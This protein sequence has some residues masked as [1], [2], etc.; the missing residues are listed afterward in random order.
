MKSI[1]TRPLTDAEQAALHAGLRSPSAFTLRRCQ[2]LLASA[3]GLTPPAIARTYGGS[4]QGVRNVL[5]AFAARGPDCLRPRSSAPKA[6]RADWPRDRDADL[7][8]LVRQSPRALG[9]ATS[10]WTLDLLAAACHES[11]WTAR[12]LSGEA[13]RR[14]LKRLG[15]G[16]TRAKHWLT[17]P[18]PEYAA[19][20]KSGTS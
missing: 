14:V 15:V 9:K 12:A 11:G 19:K 16:W 20:K 8:A 10:L 6:P 3:G 7:A 2:Y 4:D 17:S 18:D 1:T 13:I 5:R